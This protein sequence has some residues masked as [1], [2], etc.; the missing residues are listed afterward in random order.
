MDNEEAKRFACRIVSALAHHEA[1]SGTDL[2]AGLSNDDAE[3]VEEAL[4][5]LFRE[6]AARGAEDL[7]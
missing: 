4:I 1:F 5:A 3:Q 7:T 6:L 2:R